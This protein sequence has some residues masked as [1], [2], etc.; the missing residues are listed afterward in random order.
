M[1]LKEQD[2]PSLSQHIKGMSVF[3][4]ILGWGFVW[5]IVW[6]LSLPFK[7][8]RENCLT[9]ALYKWN[10]EGG[11]ITIRWCRSNL[12][13]WVKWPHF[14][15]LPEDKSEHLQHIIPVPEDEQFSYI[16]KPWF[17]ARQIHG[18]PHDVTEN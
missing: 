14:L 9:W 7:K 6:L 2:I 3:V 16:P 12:I 5:L 11:Y 18:D 15:W 8:K 4:V 13:S 1:R 17:K 10:T